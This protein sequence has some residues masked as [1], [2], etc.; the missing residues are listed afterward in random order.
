MPD[1]RQLVATAAL[2]LSI[3]VLMPTAA[4]AHKMRAFASVEGVTIRGLVF[5][6]GSVPAQ[7][8]TV[9]V[10]A[11][12]GRV[13]ATTTTDPQG[14]FSVRARQRVDHHIVADGSDGHRAEYVVRAAELPPD[15]PEG[16]EPVSGS[17]A[18]P[19]MGDASVPE[20]P[21]VG[22]PVT[23]QGETVP[24]LVDAAVARQLGP[25]REQLA[26]FEEQVWL[27]DVLGGLG[28]LLGITGL[29]LWLR[30]RRTG[31]RR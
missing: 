26:Q 4:H 12:D 11:P 3:L 19:M 27:R 30:D 22:G 7:G 10:S 18:A 14:H 23:E 8:V 2:L 1:R 5:F 31:V 25:L 29:A 20:S 15:L 28:Y 17:S 24:A 13:L 6:S 9:V 16:G 21:A